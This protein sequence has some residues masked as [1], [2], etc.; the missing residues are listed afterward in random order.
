VV[1]EL[2][3]IATVLDPASATELLT[4][5]PAN[6]SAASSVTQIPNDENYQAPISGRHAN[7]SG[8][9]L[10]YRSPY[11]TQGASQQNLANHYNYPL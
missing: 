8:S 4:M 2:C 11:F 3:E 6:S 10:E 7:T 1:C 9:K 5:L